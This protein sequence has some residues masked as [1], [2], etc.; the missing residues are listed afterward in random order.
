MHIETFDNTSNMSDEIH[1][2][3]QETDMANAVQVNFASFHKSV[4]LRYCWKAVDDVA[5]WN[6][7]RYTDNI[8]GTPQ[9]HY[10]VSRD[11]AILLVVL[12]HA[13]ERYR[14]LLLV[15]NNCLRLVQPS[16]VKPSQTAM[17]CLEAW[18]LFSV[19]YRVVEYG[20]FT[21]SILMLSD[22][23]ALKHRRNF[24]GQTYSSIAFMWTPES[25][26]FWLFVIN[27]NQDLLL[28]G[29]FLSFIN[30]Y[31]KIYRFVRDTVCRYYAEHFGCDPTW[32]ESF[33]HTFPL[34]DV[35]VEIENLFPGGL[36]GRQW[37]SNVRDWLNARGFGFFG[38]WD[39]GHPISR[40]R[41]SSGSSNNTNP[42][43]V[44]RRLWRL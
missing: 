38:S 36:D 20:C 14:E 25:L 5:F 12:K 19:E 31:G 26:L 17:D 30:S 18:L 44:V 27:R 2:T 37:F 22:S 3:L 40:S 7:V 43:S 29:T 15:A 6:V 8:D 28:S 4:K 9:R 35:T 39:I 42:T 32:K 13:C 33:V 34:H 21:T 1:S 24:A 16:S 41:V 23:A 10:L 11:Y